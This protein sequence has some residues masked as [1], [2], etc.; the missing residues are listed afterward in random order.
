MTLRPFTHLCA[1]DGQS[2]WT[3]DM[4]KNALG[5]HAPSGSTGKSVPGFW[6]SG[7]TWLLNGVPGAWV[8][9]SFMFFVNIL[10]PCDQRCLVW[11][12][13]GD[14]MLF[15]PCPYRG[16]FFFVVACFMPFPSRIS[17]LGCWS[18]MHLVRTS[19]R[20][21]IKIIIRSVS[22][23]LRSGLLSREGGELTTSRGFCILSYFWSKHESVYFMTD[24]LQQCSEPS[25][26]HQLLRIKVWFRFIISS[27][28]HSSSLPLLNLGNEWKARLIKPRLFS[29]AFG[30][31]LLRGW[32]DHQ[33]LC[34]EKSQSKE[35]K[36]AANAA[37][38]EQASG[39]AQDS[40]HEWWIL[41]LACRSHRGS[42]RILHSLRWRWGDVISQILI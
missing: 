40:Q 16:E 41:L 23:D 24:L 8:S 35:E 26:W 11:G 19:G 1:S 34:L 12:S 3:A 42:H 30:F 28:S 32:G 37:N 31:S 2:F 7:G 21:L 6:S 33:L 29:R 4:C 15:S 9:L 36:G 13:V 39:L 17:W 38:R 22:L 5:F 27:Y 10:Y 20:A 14:A 25:L 18:L